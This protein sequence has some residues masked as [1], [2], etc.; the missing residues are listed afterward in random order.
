MLQIGTESKIVLFARFTPSCTIIFGDSSVDNRP[1]SY[2]SSQRCFAIS[3]TR[4][5]WVCETQPLSREKTSRVASLNNEAHK[6]SCSVAIWGCGELREYF[7]CV[8]FVVSFFPTMHSCAGYICWASLSSV[9]SLSITEHPQGGRPTHRRLL[10][11]VG[12]KT[13]Q[14]LGHKPIV[15]KYVGLMLQKRVVLEIV[16]SW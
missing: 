12:K 3:G 15:P 6:H 11:A 8:L 1:I 10:R 2:L 7:S 14:R 16:N 13:H 5:S 4:S 9:R